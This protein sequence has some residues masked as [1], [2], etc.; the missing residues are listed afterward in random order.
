M[1]KPVPPV[2]MVLHPLHA[3]AGMVLLTLIGGEAISGEVAA[4]D[5]AIT[6]GAWRTESGKSL[7][8]GDA[9]ESL[10]IKIA[11]NANNYY[12]KGAKADGPEYDAYWTTLQDSLSGQRCFVT[13]NMTHQPHLLV[14]DGLE[15]LEASGKSFKVVST[16]IKTVEAV[17]PGFTMTTLKVQP[18]PET[19]RR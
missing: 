18:A 6:L 17:F 15:S 10:I 3:L 12:A 5:A 2:R 13:R 9:Q 16:S 11:Q 8:C 7:V 19:K 14:Y 1:I 4:G